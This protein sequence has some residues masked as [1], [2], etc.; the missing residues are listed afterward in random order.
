MWSNEDEDS[1]PAITSSFLARCDA[2]NY[3]Q[4]GNQMKY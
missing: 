2:N 4:G 3:D 1:A